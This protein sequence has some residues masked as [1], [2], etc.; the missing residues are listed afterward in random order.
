MLVTDGPDT[1][2][3]AQRVAVVIP[4]FDEA[5]IIAATVR[6]CRAIPAV[7]LVVVV[8][9]G[10]V[11]K[12]QH[13]ARG[14]GAVVVRHSVNRGKASAV[15][16]GIK[17]VAMRD[18]PDLP[19]RHVLVIDAWL[20]DAAA[21]CA[22]AVQAVLD[23]QA[24]CAIAV[25]LSHTPAGRAE[26]FARSGIARLTGLQSVQPLAPHRCLTREAANAAMPLAGGWGLEPGITIDVL[27]AG[28]TVVE[29]ECDMPAGRRGSKQH[30]GAFAHQREVATAILTRR[31]FRPPPAAPRS[32]QSDP[33]PGIPY[34]IGSK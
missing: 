3:D 24:D 21:E 5:P 11:D 25:S 27:A 30:R 9:D 26:A 8:D 13:A 31:F 17:V 15:E 20:G 4:A 16:T 10:S 7:D 28:L 1:L 19:P 23:G 14:A 18:L 34:Q 6:A 32:I 33:Q 22:P 29:V 12:T 2:R